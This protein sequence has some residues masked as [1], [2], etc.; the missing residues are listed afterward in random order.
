MGS[1]LIFFNPVVPVDLW[2]LHWMRVRAPK[3]EAL[4]VLVHIALAVHHVLLTILRLQVDPVPAGGELDV[5]LKLC[6]DA[7]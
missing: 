2:H 1:S 7:N 5:D 6:N 3:L 4:V